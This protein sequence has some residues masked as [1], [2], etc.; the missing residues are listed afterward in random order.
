MLF[1]TAISICIRNNRMI[2]LE[3]LPEN[4]YCVHLGFL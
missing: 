1:I 2:P 3:L 4:G